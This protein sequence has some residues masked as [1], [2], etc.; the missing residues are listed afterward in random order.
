[1][2]V[3]NIDLKINILKKTQIFSSAS[4]EVLEQIANKL[5]E[6]T[7]KED[8][9]IFYKGDR[10]HAMYIIEKGSVKVHDKN[11]VFDILK[12]GDVFGEYSLIDTEVRSATITGAEESILYSLEKASFYDLISSNQQVLQGILNLMVTRLRKLDVIQ[13]ELAQKKSQIEKQKEEILIQNDSLTTLNEEKN[14]LIS[15]VAHDIRNPLASAATFANL[16]R[17]DAELL[18]DDHNEYV[19]YLLRSLNRMTDLVTRILDVKTIEDKTLAVKPIKFN[20]R[21]EME[22]LLESQ[23]EKI[24]NKHLKLIDEID[25]TVCILDQGLFRQ[26]AENLLTNAIKFSPEEKRI[27]VKL[28]KE[29]KTLKLEIRDEGPGFTRKDMDKLFGK[30]QQ[31]SAKPTGGESSTGLGLSIVKKFTDSMKGKVKCDPGDPRAG[32]GATFFVELPLFYE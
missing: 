3:A 20:I 5:K 4:R 9:T 21:E 16:L 8:E 14:H 2:E 6:I 24:E 26:I 28:R 29:D 19:T 22:D 15:I 10:G 25:D 23:R 18:S 31:L 13:E 1:M 7:L 30:F 27:W 32:K 12:A 11:H 17:S